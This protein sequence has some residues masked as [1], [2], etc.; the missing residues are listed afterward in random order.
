MVLTSV[1]RCA[2]VELS[3]QNGGS[4]MYYNFK[5]R[6]PGLRDV[7]P[8]SEVKVFKANPDGTA[9][10]LLRIEKP[11]YITSKF[12]SEGNIKNQGEPNE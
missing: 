10:K 11:T 8:A 1:Y 2:I 3:N 5:R 4:K 7:A 12:I 9:G 6:V